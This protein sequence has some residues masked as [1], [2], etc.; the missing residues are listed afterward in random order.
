MVAG[1]LAYKAMPDL[2]ASVVLSDQIGVLPVLLLACFESFAGRQTALADL[3]HP[4][5][6]CGCKQWIMMQSYCLSK[7]RQLG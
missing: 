7:D 3:S 1:V 5:E 4:A 6:S 2:S